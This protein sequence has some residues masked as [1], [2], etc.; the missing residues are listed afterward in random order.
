MNER[1]SREAVVAGCRRMNAH[2]IN[3]GTS[4]NVSVRVDG[5]MLVSPSGIPYERM[6]PGDVVKVHFD[7]TYAGALR[8][9]SEWR[10]HLDL[11]REHA[12]AGAVVHAHP[13]HCTALAIRH[14][15][16]PPLHYMIA[17]AGGPNIRCADYATFGTAALSRNVLAAMEGRRACLIANH[18]MIAIGD[19]LERALWLAVEVETLARQYILSLQIGG[20]KL[21][22]EEEIARV[23]EKFADY[24]YR[25][26]EL[27][28]S[29]QPR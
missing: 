26:P 28:M 21:L 7:G 3:H 22:A 14:M 11:L 10:F 17:A 8:P 2:G 6:R 16:I 27:E 12:D 20:P 19:D 13:D 29:P 23:L 4:G 18:G 9:S 5:G 15:E 25:D 24:G 1:A